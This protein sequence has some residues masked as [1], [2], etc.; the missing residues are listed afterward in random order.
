MTGRRDALR[1]ALRLYLIS[2]DGWGADPQ[3]HA[4]LARIIQAGVG[5]VQFRDKSDTPRRLDRAKTMRAICKEHGALFLI[6]DDP[7]FAQQVD[8]DG[9]HVGVDDAA[10]AD[11][12]ALLG[13]DKIVG[14]TARTI[15]RAREAVAEGADYLG[16]GAIYDATASKSDAITG[17]LSLLTMMRA[18]TVVAETLIVAIGGITSENASVCFNAGADGVAMI[19]GLWQLS[20]PEQALASLRVASPQ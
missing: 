20:A 1:D 12:R 8:A 3:D 13:P 17:G 16:V 9:V 18:D 7:A 4:R 5:C 6:N 19:R 11:A 15:D 2:P 10:V 14:A